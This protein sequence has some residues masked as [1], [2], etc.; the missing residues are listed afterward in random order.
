MHH[1]RPRCN[2]RNSLY[3][4][5]LITTALS[6]LMAGCT[7]NPAAPSS[8]ST[9]QSATTATPAPT[10]P[11]VPAPDPAPTPTPGPSPTPSP[12]P[13]T[14][15]PVPV[16]VPPEPVRYA[17]HVEN[18]HWYGTPLFEGPDIEIVRYPDRVVLG[19]LSLPIAYQDDRGLIARTSDMS[20]SVVDSSWTFNGIAGQGSGV[21]TKK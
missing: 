5:L 19:P 20:F 12:T 10:P 13:P 1:A 3:K 2:V 16:P 21:W 11:P 8:T 9:N 17:A 7:G 18:V 4:Q 14:P 6:L 15:T